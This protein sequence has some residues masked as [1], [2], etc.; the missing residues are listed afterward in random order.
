MIAFLNGI[1]HSK[2]E[3]A[4]ILDVNGVGYEVMLPASDWERLAPVGEPATLFTWYQNREDAVQLFGF[5]QWESRQLF[6]LLLSVSGIGP[7]SALAV[8]SGL[9]KPDLEQAVARKDIQA[10]SRLPGIGRKTAERLI[11]ELKDKLK[12]PPETGPTSMARIGQ[13]DLG[14]ALEALLALGYSAHQARNALQKVAE[15]NIAIPPGDERVAFFVRQALK[16]L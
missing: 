9:T 12:V 13:E 4:C 15:Q 11:L 8:L 14:L 5:L 6:K 1:V 2:H 3:G 7:K 10:F 16:L